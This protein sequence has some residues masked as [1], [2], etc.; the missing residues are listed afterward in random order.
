MDSLDL[1]KKSEPKR[2]SVLHLA[3]ERGDDID[4]VRQLMDEGLSIHERDHKGNDALMLAVGQARVELVSFLLKKGACVDTI[5][6]HGVSA[7]VI[8]LNRVLGKSWGVFDSARKKRQEISNLL[9]DYGATVLHEKHHVCTLRDAV[10]KHNF[11]FV[12]RLVESAKPNRTTEELWATMKG[13]ALTY[14][15]EHVEDVSLETVRLLV[16]RSNAVTP[17]N[18]IYATKTG[19]LDLVELLLD[20]GADPNA[21]P[22]VRFPCTAWLASPNKDI[23]KLFWDRGGIDIN[24][25]DE[26]GLR[27]LHHA[28]KAGAADTV[29]FLLSL[30]ELDSKTKEKAWLLTRSKDIAKMLWESGDIDANASDCDGNTLLHLATKFGIIDLVKYLTSLDSIDPTKKNRF[31]KDPLQLATTA[32]DLVS[33]EALLAMDVIGPESRNAAW[34]TISRGDVAQKFWEGGRVDVNVSDELGNTLLHLAI[35]FGFLDVVQVLLTI[36]EV[37]IT[38]NNLRGDTPL[39]EAA[40]WGSDEILQC[41]VQKNEPLAVTDTLVRAAQRGRLPCIF[42]LLR[43]KHVKVDAFGSCGLTALQQAAS[44]GQRFAVKCLLDPVFC[45]NARMPSRCSP[46]RSA[47]ELALQNG[48][49]FVHQMLLEQVCDVYEAVLVG[50]G[51]GWFSRCA[52]PEVLGIHRNDR[53]RRGPAVAMDADMEDQHESDAETNASSRKRKRRRRIHPRVIEGG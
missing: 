3:I 35:L 43:N 29:E 50:A 49:H 15:L 24:C 28:V 46:P 41:L 11:T 26:K 53:V 16:D 6:R 2:K 20:F 27:L 14:T 34:L 9:L 18:L 36:P 5:N 22:D 45:A 37:D 21:K 4:L 38:T 10:Y 8:S 30:D 33:I 7:L 40:A 17:I 31:G 44:N 42:K 32:Q 52:R 1:T 25:F 51:S 19:R 13:C 23:A 48:H 12:K 39:Y 47:I